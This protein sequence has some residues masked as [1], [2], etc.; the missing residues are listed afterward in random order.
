MRTWSTAGL[1]AEGYLACR[2]AHAAS[3]SGDRFDRSDSRADVVGEGL[4][5]SIGLHAVIRSNTVAAHVVPRNVR[6]RFI[7]S[8]HR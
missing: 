1:L 7:S 3:A 5:R 8:P 2:D 6:G 4:D